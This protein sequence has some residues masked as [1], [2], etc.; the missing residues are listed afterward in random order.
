MIPEPTAASRS[1]EQK[2]ESVFWND[3]LFSQAILILLLHAS[4]FPGRTLMMKRTP[5][6][7]SITRR[8][9]LGMRTEGVW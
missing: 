2:Y 9:S 6:L 3:H 5:L 7:L 8:M 4:G 1:S